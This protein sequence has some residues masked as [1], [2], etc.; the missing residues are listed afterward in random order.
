MVYQQGNIVESAQKQALSHE[1]LKQ[2]IMKT[3]A[4]P[5]AIQN[6]D[7]EADDNIYIGISAINEIRRAATDALQQAILKKSKR[8]AKQYEIEKRKQIP[9]IKT[10]KLNVLVSTREQ[11]DVV[12]SDRRVN[13]L[14]YE[15]TDDFKKNYSKHIEKCHSNHIKLY[16]ALPRIERKQCE[17][18]YIDIIEILKKSDIDG[19]LVRSPGQFLEIS[20]TGKKIAIDYNM[21]VFNGESVDYWQK[22]GADNIC[23]SLES[24]LQ[25]INAIANE[26]CEMVVYGYLPLMITQQCP[27]GNYAGGKIEGIYCS[28]KDNDDLYF[29]KDRKGMKFPLMPDCKQCVCTILN[30]KPLFT[31]KF[32][33]EILQSTTGSIRLLFTKEGSRRTER[34]LNAY[35][36]MTLYDTVP[37]AETKI[38]LHEMSEKGNTKGHY[39]R[40]VE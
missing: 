36:E 24:N 7:I 5:F 20:Q 32:Y 18:L 3:G 35:A 40:G 14:Y 28:E 25:E 33:D 21:N 10:K 4:T 30:G 9:I 16:A 31:L 11:F 6:L 19:F 29:L 13:I 37:T 34:I 2:Q 26:H 23:I 12:S 15:L 8:K 22:K 38:L 39:F 1:K 17:N 27:I